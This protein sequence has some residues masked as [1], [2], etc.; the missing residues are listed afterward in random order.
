[1]GQEAEERRYR[2]LFRDHHAAFAD[3][4]DPDGLGPAAPPLQEPQA[5]AHQLLKA[6]TFQEIVDCHRAVLEEVGMQPVACHRAAFEAVGV[7]TMACH[8]A[9]L[10]EVGVQTLPCHFVT[11]APQ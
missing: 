4:M 8:R 3:L 2:E 9:V 11:M 10:A 1:M 7:H 5:P 6:A